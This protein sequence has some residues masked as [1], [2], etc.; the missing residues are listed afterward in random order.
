MSFEEIFHPS[1]GHAIDHTNAEKILPAPAPAPGDKPLLGTD[2]DIVI[3]EVTWGAGALPEPPA[4]TQD[5]T[6]SGADAA[7]PDADEA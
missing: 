3:P 1:L 5:T 6:A 4:A 2:D 7:T